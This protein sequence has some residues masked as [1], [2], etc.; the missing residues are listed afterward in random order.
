MC[1]F[2]LLS[3]VSAV[4]RV[5]LIDG[6]SSMKFISRTFQI[7]FLFLVSVYWFNSKNECVDLNHAIQNAFYFK[8]WLPSLTSCIQTSD[9][10]KER[11][12]KKKNVSS[13]L[14]LDNKKKLQQNILETYNHYY[15]VRYE[16]AY[17]SFLP[18]LL[19]S[20]GCELNF[21]EWI[22]YWTSRR[23]WH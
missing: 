8:F 14:W 6:V 11:E 1:V 9:W 3:E 21:L 2:L 23:Q 7:A 15:I 20:I 12:K 16:S 22:F 13:Q 10:T 4:Y 19:Y 17:Y 18:H 5:R